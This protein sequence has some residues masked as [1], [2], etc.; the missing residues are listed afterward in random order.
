M[1]KYKRII[2]MVLSCALLA[3]FGNVQI[4]A[5]EK[6]DITFG[7]DVGGPASRFSTK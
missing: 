5:A 3:G 6:S 4:E 2:A 1:K 7:A